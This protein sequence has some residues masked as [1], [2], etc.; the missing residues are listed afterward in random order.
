MISKKIL[1][2]FG[3]RPEIIKLAPV[4][5][6]FKES[7]LKDQIIVVS[8]AQHEELLDEQ[9]TYWKIIPDYILAPTSDKRDLTRLLSW[10]LLG[11]KDIIEKVG[12]IEYVVVQGDTNSALACANLCFL[13]QIKLIHIEAGLRSFDFQNP[14]PEEFNR[15][16]ASKVAYFNFAPT[17]FAKENL[18]AEGIPS[19]KIKVVGN[20]IVDALYSM[21][22]MNNS[23]YIRKSVLITLHRRENIDKNYLILIDVVQDLVEY[24]PELNF[25]WISHPNCISNIKNRIVDSNNFKIYDH[26]PYGEFVELYHSSKMIITDS[27]GVS[28]EAIQLG[29]PLMIFRQKT[30]RVEALSEKY[31]MIVSL[32]KADLLSFFHKHINHANTIKYSYGDGKA[33]QRILSW[34]V[35]ELNAVANYDVL[36]IGGGP[37]GT[38]LLLKSIKDGESNKFLDKKIALIEKS[39]KLMIGNL[40]QYKVNSDTI[41]DVFLECL[42]G[43][44][45]HFIEL[46]KLKSEVDFIA[47]F[48][49]RSIPLEKLNAFYEKLGA[50]LKESLIERKKCDF[51]MNSLV[52]KVEKN[53]VGA[54]DVFIEGNRSPITTRKIIIATGGIPCNIIDSNLEFAKRISLNEFKNKIIHSDEILRFGVSDSLKSRLVENSKVVILGGSH[55]AFSIAHFLL[56]ISDTLSFRTGDIKIWCNEVPKIYF[57][58]REEAEENSYFD[59][60]DDDFCPITKKL[61]R[62]AGLRMDGRDLYMK[63]QGIGFSEKET[64]VV[65]NLFNEQL[66]QLNSDL[67]NAE[68]IILAFGYKFNVFP[69]YD[70]NKKRIKL[71]GEQTDH[72]VNDKCELLDENGDIVANVFASGMATGFIPN[73]TLGGEPSFNGQTNGIWYYQNAIADLII[74]NI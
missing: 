4:I 19:S 66:E 21:N 5:K 65:L 73:G 45:R 71:L 52:Y 48:N 68:L 62:L 41:S 18:L 6:T 61:Y 10:T 7:V 9:L 37:A 33:S 30:E 44:T 36:I 43:N 29:L 32:I 2:V 27:G 20:T 24:Y 74:N 56:N 51:Y 8:T 22:K 16:V 47:A 60:T 17:E 35:E 64:R 55:S 50:M 69:I 3:T 46:K 15:I 31:P 39:S 28:E 49:G 72:W 12:T 25:I 11:L 54:Y 1:F 23:G 38:G 67:R 40:T 14:F 59:F 57:N 13:S 58:S 53:D 26:L 63:M 70:F 42:E 34:F